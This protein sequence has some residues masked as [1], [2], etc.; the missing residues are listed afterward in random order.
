MKFKYTIFYVKS[1]EASLD[2]YERA[3]GISRKMLHESGVYGEMDT[4]GT[5]LAF[6]S[7]E[8]MRQLGKHI[9]PPDK[10]KA[11][12]EIAF[13]T[14]DVRGALTRAAKAGAEILQE[15]RDEEW[16]QTTSYVADPDGFLI[17]ICS[18]VRNQS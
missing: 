14:D 3:F 10:H 2:F 5:T 1:V 17:E 9:S 8:Q 13:E 6:T 16:G 11:C 7:V 15:A 4:G 18:P 12:N